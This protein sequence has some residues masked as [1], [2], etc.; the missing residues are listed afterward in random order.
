MV[1]LSPSA[2][3]LQKLLDIS[4]VYSE[5]HDV[6]YNV[7]KSVCMVINNN[8]II[9]VLLQTQYMVHIKKQD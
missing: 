3:A 1:I 9:K 6:V 8:I 2:N 4:G 5:K 7:K